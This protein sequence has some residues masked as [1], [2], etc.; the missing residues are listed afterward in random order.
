MLF[1]L[2]FANNSILPCFLFFFLFVGSYFL[3]LT[4]IAQTF[5]PIAELVI[6]KET[7]AEMETRPVTVEITISEC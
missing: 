1:N 4:G 3:I 2:D 5:D 6:P 7:K